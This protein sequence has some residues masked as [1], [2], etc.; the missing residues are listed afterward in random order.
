MH[1]GFVVS[2]HANLACQTKGSAQRD[3][4]GGVR[5]QPVIAMERNRHHPFTL[6][7]SC[8]FRQI[9]DVAMGPI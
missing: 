2:S 8:C 9:G 4:L 7:L 5:H 1:M 6:A 3:T